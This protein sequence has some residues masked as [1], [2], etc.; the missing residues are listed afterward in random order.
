MATYLA[1]RVVVFDGQ[2]GVKGAATPPQN[3]VTGRNKF[4]QSLDITFWRD[5]TNARPRINKLNS[6]KDVDQKK[7]G[8]YFF[9][10]D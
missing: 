2:P 7:S 3:L 5:P 8:N 9:L 1:D 6:V 4:L 10:G